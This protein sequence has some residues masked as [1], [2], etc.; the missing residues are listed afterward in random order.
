MA[1][2]NTTNLSLIKPEVGASADTWGGKLNT[3][4]DTI[5]G[6]FKDDGTGTSVGLQVGSGKT[7]K[8]TG[9]CNLDTAVTINDSGADVDFRIESD[10]NANAFFLDGATGNIG[11]SLTPRAWSG[12]RAVDIAGP[13]AIAS[14]DGGDTFT[15]VAHGSWFDG[16]NW[17]YQYTGVGA[18][19]YQMTGPSGG[20][21]HS[22]YVAGTG[23]AG[24]AITFTQAM[25]L[26]AS[27][28]LGLGVT[29]PTSFIHA[30]DPA[31]ADTTYRFEPST[32][33]YKS[34]LYV[35]SSSSGD[36]GIRYDSNLN[37]T[38][39]ISYGNMLFCVG[40]TNISGSVGDERARITSGGDLLV[41][42]TS[43]GTYGGVVAAVDIVRTTANQ[44]ALSVKNATAA[45]QTISVWNAVDTGTIYFIEF[46]DKVSR[47]T[48]GSITSNG[49]L[50]AYNTSS[51]RRLKENIAPADDAG[52]VIDA[53]KIVKHDWKA[54]GHTRYGAIAQDLH[55][56]APEAVT[57]G[58]DGEE[59][60]RAWGV[61]YS[62]LV[63][64]L[65]KEIQSLRARVAALE[66]A[67]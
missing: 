30:K 45:Q 12:Y 6:I 25:T 11:I 31:A 39:L 2:T 56:V 50:T 16:T 34:T 24:N 61:D 44:S 22:W 58:D 29:S 37:Q 13:G 14:T 65:V 20:G 47:T 55:A 62:K 27:G 23:T 60:E 18:A 5:D 53:I 42:T 19:R 46:A 21:N 59:V 33:S 66:G 1:D 17:I 54:G 15:Q 35:S 41:G 36:G 64:M 7:L 57:V 43:N 9:T 48:R 32:N 40:T 26:T 67:N 38:T 10:T 63:P 51:D 4:L 49:T 3:N 28:R 8:V 52:S